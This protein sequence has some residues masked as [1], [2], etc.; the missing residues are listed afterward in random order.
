MLLGGPPFLVML[1]PIVIARAAFLRDSGGG[2]GCHRARLG[3]GSARCSGPAWRA[4]LVP[5]ARGLRLEGGGFAAL[6][7][8]IAVFALP[9]VK[10]HWGPRGGADSRLALGSLAVTGLAGLVRGEEIQM[11]P[12]WPVY[13]AF[14]GSPAM[15]APAARRSCGASDAHT[16]AR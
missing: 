13:A 12:L 7:A 15:L 5:A 3:P 16:A 9:F 2:A 10:E 8:S 14:A 1:P 11:L 6:G 4:G